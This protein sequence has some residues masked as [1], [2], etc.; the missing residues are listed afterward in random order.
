ME[1]AHLKEVIISC[2]S[3]GNYLSTKRMCSVHEYA[4]VGLTFQIPTNSEHC[5]RAG[6]ANRSLLLSHEITNMYYLFQSQ[7]LSEKCL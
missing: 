5:L 4:E 2:K 3:D 7:P 1:H 6:G